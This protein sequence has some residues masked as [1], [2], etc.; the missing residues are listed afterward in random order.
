M[1]QKT[2]IALAVAAALTLH[3][4]GCGKAPDSAAPAATAQTETVM[5]KSGI[6]LGNLDTQ[7]KPQ[8]DFF[9]YV[10]G[11]W[12]AKTEI[13]ADKS[14]WGSFDELRYNAEKHVLELVQQQAAKPAELG[15]DAQKIGD[16]YRAFMDTAAIDALGLTP[17]NADIAAID[18]IKTPAELAVLWGKLQSQRYGTPLTLFVGQDQ[19]NSTQY[20]SL[21]NQSGLG[22]PD[23]D[24]YLKTDEK[25]EKI[26]QQYRWMIAKFWELAGW[27]DGTA[28]ADRIYAIEQQLATIQWSRVQNRDRTA[29]YNKMT[30]AEL[31]TAA[32]GFDW[33]GFLQGAGMQTIDSLVVRQP[34]Y[35]TEFAKLQ[36][37]ISL[38]DWQLYLKFHLIRSHAA[39]LASGFEQ[40]S[41]DFYGRALNGLQQQKPREERA[42]AAIDEALGFM[43]G[44]LY[45][46][47][48]F[49]PEA[50]ARMEQLI[51]NLRAAFEQSINGLEWM[52]PETKQ[53]A[54]AKLV[55]FNTKIGYPDVWRDYSC[56]EVKAGDLVGNMQRSSA[57]EYQRNTGRLGKPVDRTDWGMTPQT[58]NAYYSS[59][60]NEIVF[61]AAILQPPFFNVEADDA[62]NYGAIGGVIGHEITHGF[63]DQ[64]RRS[65]G[66]GNL[67]DWWTPDDEQKFKQ[68]AQQM[69][70]QYSAFNPIDDLHLQGAL[71]LGENI[72]DLGGLTVSYRAYQN[73]LAGKPAPVIDGFTGEKR[74]FSGWA[75]VWRI[76]FRDEALRQQIITGPHSPG[77]YRVLGVLSNMPEFYQAYDV[78]PGDGMYRPDEVRVKIW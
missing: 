5:L 38:A 40:A 13:P 30:P 12:L 37:Q 10:N 21:V 71:G 6:E 36:S 47:K 25:A 23:R 48:H 24:N 78:K 41:F 9:R 2:M 3:L 52:S 70:D 55:K 76:K 22:M 4:T 73:S 49:K 31:A 67:R 66:D 60:M 18:A 32:P 58:V 7:M 77:M 17:L 62:V 28:A 74:F 63:D 50:K 45:V 1:S 14:R 16:L 75:Q 29:T 19:K 39:L 43:V 64:G 68:R 46:E 59:T 51:K 57:C 65:D 61:P 56:L 34:T 8:Q 11:N 26:K 33:A 27:P 54:L 69:I 44:K 42:V 72:A 20:I 35:L 15:T 53:Q